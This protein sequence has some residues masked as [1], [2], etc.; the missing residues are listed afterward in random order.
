[1]NC[2][3]II[4]GDVSESVAALAAGEALICDPPK[5]NLQGDGSPATENSA[6]VSL[7]VDPLKSG[8]LFTYC[9]FPE[10]NFLLILNKFSENFSFIFNLS[11]WNPVYV[12]GLL[13]FCV[14]NFWIIVIRTVKTFHYPHVVVLHWS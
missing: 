6:I 7:P 4:E 12:K 14:L 1:M 10:L 13:D 2:S 11:L 9:L 8:K 5:A 3:E